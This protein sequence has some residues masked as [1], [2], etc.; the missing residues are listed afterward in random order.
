MSFDAVQ[1]DLLFSTTIRRNVGIYCKKETN[2][3]VSNNV[4]SQS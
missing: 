3:W 2:D 1:D 4:N